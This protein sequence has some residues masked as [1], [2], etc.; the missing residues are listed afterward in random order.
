MNFLKK[1]LSKA[2]NQQASRPDKKLLHKSSEVVQY[3]DQVIFQLDVIGHWVFLNDAWTTHTG[4]SVDESLGKSFL[5]YVH[6]NDRDLCNQNLIS[7]I[8]DGKNSIHIRARFITREERYFWAY[9]HANKTRDDPTA[10]VGSFSDI[11]DEVHET[12]L[13]HA[14]HR[15]LSSLVNNVSGLIYRGRNDH[16]WT[17][18]YV[19]EGS[20]ELTG[21]K[22]EE[23]INKSVTFASLIH[24]D[25]REN[26]WNEV[27]L[28]LNDRTP[29]ELIYRL[30]TISGEEKWVWERAQGIFSSNGELLGLEG[31][32]TD[33]TSWKKDYLQS[34]NDTLYVGG[35][36]L[37]RRHLF[38]DRLRLAI[39]RSTM[40]SNFNYA[41]LMI[42]ADRLNKIASNYSEDDREELRSQIRILL[43]EIIKPIDTICM[44]KD[45]NFSILIENIDSLNQ[46]TDITQRIHNKLSSPLKIKDSNIFITVSIGVATGSPH[47]EDHNHVIRDANTALIRAKVLG[48]GCF[49]LFDEILNSKVSLIHRMESEIKKAIAN[50]EIQILY[51][52]VIFS[53]NDEIAGLI[54]V[55]VW[56]HPRKGQIFLK[57]YLSI[58]EEKLITDE[59]NQHILHL[60]CDQIIHWDS[61][62]Q[63]DNQLFL[64]L[65]F[66]N[67]PYIQKGF[68]EQLEELLI[69]KTGDK[70]KY[71][72]LITDEDKFSF[73]K[74]ES[75]FLQQF[76]SNNNISICLDLDERDLTSNND[77]KRTDSDMI[78]LKDPVNS[79]KTD[80]YATVRSMIESI[81]QYDI[82]VVISNI[83]LDTEMDAIRSLNADYFQGSK[84]CEPVDFNTIDSILSDPKWPWT[85]LVSDQENL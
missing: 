71:Y 17:M 69:R 28:A 57:N 64:I 6:P 61:L 27:Q 46:I 19:S 1:L 72:L 83:Y 14:T 58:A 36:D 43:S 12:G 23:L 31:L 11:S 15:S 74:E 65:D 22:P 2:N 53:Q 50:N 85:E 20:Y 47:Y 48:G 24:P 21:Y 5:E 66:F 82:P 33:I 75:D 68:I 7:L 49:E 34:L 18:E 25:D 44:I 77:I 41:L 70:L 35:T 62:L 40:V 3:L 55:L 51:Q 8:N 38:I 60:L 79:E 13:S 56:A 9:I 4:F 16:D 81:H 45:D 29:F 30:K 73:S 52:P 54:P 84:I 37:T 26:V 42:Q 78:M 63:F 10:I 67:S 76:C 80:R 59:L 32:M 39:A